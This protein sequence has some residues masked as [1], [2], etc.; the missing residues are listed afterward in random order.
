MEGRQK[1]TDA[2]EALAHSA[3][4]GSTEIATSGALLAVACLR[5]GLK[6]WSP[7]LWDSAIVAETL[8]RRQRGSKEAHPKIFRSLFLRNHGAAPFSL[9][10][11]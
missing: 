1:P 7:V 11:G 3:E 5:F 6:R 9:R 10:F 4:A 8:V 2:H